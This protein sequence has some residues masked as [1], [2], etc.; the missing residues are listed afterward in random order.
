MF[1]MSLWENNVFLNE[2]QKPRS[3]FG[4][5]NMYLLLNHF[6]SQFS[7]CLF[8]ILYVIPNQIKTMKLTINT[9]F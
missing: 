4:H 5:V 9:Y 1:Q 3:D 8:T 6:F 7:F 2:S